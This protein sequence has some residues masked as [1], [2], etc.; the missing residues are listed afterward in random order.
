MGFGAK[1][2]RWMDG[3]IFSSDMSVLI[4]GSITK[5]FKVEKGLHQ[6]DLLSPFLFVLVTEVLTT[7]M[8]KTIAIGDFRGFKINDVEEVSMLQFADDTIILAE[9]D[10]ANLWSMKSILRVFE[11]MS[12]LR[13]NFHKSNIYGINVGEWVGDSPRKLSMWR[14]L[15]LALKNRITVWKRVHLN[16]AVRKAPSKILKEITAIQRV[17]VCTVGNGLDLPFWYNCW[18]DTQLLLM[19][20]PELYALA[21]NDYIT[22]AEAG[23]HSVSGWA[24][25]ADAILQ[26]SSDSAV[27]PWQELSDYISHVVLTDFSKDEFVW[28]INQERVFTVK[29]Y[30]KWFKAKLSNHL[31]ILMLLKLLLLFGR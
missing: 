1:W 27:F 6:G 21:C 29:T 23:S 12:G 26:D 13:L 17:V 16:I 3:S 19:A 7:L 14:D 25:N 4:N 22:V 28:N 11:L 2:L 31:S 8:R 20:F 10:I 9:G 5:D 15:I 24:W 30:Y 18:A